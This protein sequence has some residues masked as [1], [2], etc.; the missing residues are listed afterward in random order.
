MFT[1]DKIKKSRAVLAYLAASAFCA[2]FGAIYEA[3]SHGV[4]SVYMGFAFLIPALAGAA[5]FAILQ[6]TGFEPGATARRLWHFGAATLTVG[7]LFRGVIDIYGTDSPYCA[8]YLWA[9]SALL[10]SGAI[11]AAWRAVR[12]R[13]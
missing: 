4:F 11:C 7:S 10:L 9:G 2:L 1:S 5:V 13:R 12:R 3:F 8:V 6:K